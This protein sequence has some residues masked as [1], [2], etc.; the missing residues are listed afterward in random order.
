MLR[1]D[2]QVK[3]KVKIIEKDEREKVIRSHISKW[4]K[5]EQKSD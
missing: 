2:L 1:E 3:Y 5:S 4:K